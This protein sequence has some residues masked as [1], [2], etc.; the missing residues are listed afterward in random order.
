MGE[1]PQLL[2]IGAVA[3][4]GI[5]HTVVP[6]HWVPIT[7]IARQRGWSR[8][9]T[10]RNAFV[11]GTGHVVSTLII[12]GIVW[13][14]G[15]AFAQRFGGL[16]DTVTS[17]ALIGFGL[18][19]AI[20]AWLEV[21]AAAGHHHHHGGHAHGHHH[22]QHHHHHEHEMPALLR[23]GHLHRHDGGL[24]HVH[25]HDH[26]PAT[27]HAIAIGEPPLH[28]HAHAATGRTALL[29]ILG[30]SPMV[31]GIPAFFAAGRYGA[32]LIA[33][34]AAVF[35]AATIATYVGL[36]VVSVTSLNRVTLGP[37]ER[38][39]EVLS[40]AVIAGLGVVFWLWPVL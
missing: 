16:V 3:A 38:W 4:V 10:A 34:M 17:L 8:R 35:A 9:E 15:A 30:S 31:E 23:H 14:A 12:A 1:T 21:H 6:D 22:H 28:D 13:G 20:S 27:A 5:L 18:W 40:G 29:L 39:G 2:L 36:C 11:A 25:R 37:F 32:G 7:L 33:V 19:I 24:V 26:A